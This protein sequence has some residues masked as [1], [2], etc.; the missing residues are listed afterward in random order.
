M[1]GVAEPVVSMGRVVEVVGD[2]GIKS[3][4]MIR[5]Y[6]DTLMI[7][8]LKAHRPAKFNP[9]PHVAGSSDVLPAELQPDPVPT[10]DE[11]APANP[12]V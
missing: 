11:A 7:Q 1:E 6:S 8:L 12:I 5:K 3:P 4:L 2:D 10:P 9:P